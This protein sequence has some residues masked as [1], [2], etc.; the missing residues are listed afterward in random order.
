MLEVVHAVTHN[1]QFWRNADM[2]ELGELYISITLKTF[3]FSMIGVF[4]PIYLYQIGFSL[5]EIA[6]YYAT[7]FAIRA[8]FNFL[9]GE[10]TA[11]RGPKHIMSYAYVL[12]LVNLGMLF[13]MESFN[14][15]LWSLA[16]A[17]A[18]SLSFFFTGYHVD[19]SRIKRTKEVGSELSHMY[20]LQKVASAVGPLLGGLLAMTFGI[21]F[22]IGLSIVF[23]LL[24]IWPLMLTR[25]PMRQRSSMSF[26][27]IS[28]RR[29]FRNMVAFGAMGIGRQMALSMWPLYIAVFIFTEN[30]YGMVGLVTSISVISSIVMAKMIGT[31]ID[32]NKGGALLEHST[33]FLTVI[34]ALRAS[35][36]TLSGVIG[37]NIL[38]EFSETGVMLPLTK[39][40][41]A[42]ADGAKDRI[43]Y[44]VM[45]ETSI[46]LVRAVFWLFVA[47][48]L[49]NLDQ[50]LAMRVVFIFVALITPL[51]LVQ[52][53]KA[54]KVQR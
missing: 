51:T 5:Q 34:H 23:V 53:F 41:Y 15:P 10:L 12:T 39:G 46:V 3:A 27:G 20:L 13:T 9:A 35:V 52:N 22:V 32:N 16:I 33:V 28:P 29:E 40:F 17:A 21:H 43:A 6:L 50:Q 2:S 24:A 42:R 54:I 30:I 19:F 8:P 47:L 44:V 45:M 25:E 1:K 31:L 38:G 11:R 4:V 49:V 48:L 37:L 26:K 7:Y 36:S 18:A 14:W